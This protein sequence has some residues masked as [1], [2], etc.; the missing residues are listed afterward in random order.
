M[1]DK[2]AVYL[3][4]TVNETGCDDVLSPLSVSAS[5]ATID[6]RLSWP[7]CSVHSGGSTGRPLPKGGTSQ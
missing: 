5:L 1:F 3:A 2:W 4:F 7:D 6:V